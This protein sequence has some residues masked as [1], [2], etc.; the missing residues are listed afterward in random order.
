M[1][2]V[3]KLEKPSASAVAHRTSASWLDSLHTNGARHC[4]PAASRMRL[5]LGEGC[6]YCRRSRRNAVISEQ[7]SSQSRGARPRAEDEIGVSMSPERDHAVHN[8]CDLTVDRVGLICLPQS[9]ELEAR[10][11]MRH[12]LEAM[13]APVFDQE[14]KNPILRVDVTKRFPFQA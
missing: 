13:L 8:T 14:P 3:V 9:G 6:P 5:V 1:H 11:K 7:P 2:T 4:H 10:G 12:H